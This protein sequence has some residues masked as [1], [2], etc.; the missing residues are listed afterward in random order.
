MAKPGSRKAAQEAP[1]F[2][3][4]VVG[5]LPPLYAIRALA[6]TVYAA[7]G[8]YSFVAV[9]N[10]VNQL[11]SLSVSGQVRMDLAFGT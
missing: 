2:I 6:P 8:V 10:T 9:N 4:F 3:P 1:L 5:Q 7:E 11:L